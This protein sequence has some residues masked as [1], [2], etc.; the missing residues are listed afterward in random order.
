MRPAL[1][2]I[3]L[4]HDYLRRADLCPPPALLL[5]QAAR[6]LH[7]FR[8]CGLPVVHAHT[9]VRRDGS[10]RMPHWKRADHS[11]CVEGSE[12]TAAPA[13]VAPQPGE[14]VVYKQFFTAFKD[15]E[16]T[17]L[18]RRNGVDTLVVAGVH[19][20]ACVRTSVVDAY[21]AGFGVWLAG[22]AVASY[23]PLHAALTRSYLDGRACRVLDTQQILQRLPRPPSQHDHA[24]REP[25]ALPWG[26]IAGQWIPATDQPTVVRRNPSQWSEPIASVPLAQPSDVGQAIAA[27]AQ[28]QTRWAARPVAHRA[29]RLEAWAA[30]LRCKQDR[31]VELMGKELGKPRREAVGEF[32]YAIR[33]LT[34]TRQRAHESPESQLP[35]GTVVRHRPLGAV[36]LI[37][38][39]NN[40]IA[41]PV[42][43]IA[44]ALLWGNAVVW[45]PAV[46]APRLA[47]L[48]MESLAD[49]DLAENVSMIF[50]AAATART[51]L[52][53]ERIAAISFTGSHAAGREVAATCAVTHKQLQAELGGNNGAVI[54]G[55][56]SVAKAA[57]D[58]AAA[59]FSFGG[60]RCTAT[61][62]VIVDRR[63]YKVFLNELIKATVALAVG[64]V[65][66]AATRLGPL[67]SRS[68]QERIGHV[69]AAAKRGGA[70]VL[71]GGRIPPG[72]E[73]G[74]WY[75]PTILT[76]VEAESPVAQEE[77]FGPVVIISDY[78]DFGEAMHRLNDVPQGLVATLY[79]NDF[80]LQ[81]H[82]CDTAQAGILRLNDAAGPIDADAPFSGWKVS[83]IGPAEHGEGDYA[84]YT[85]PQ[86]VYGKTR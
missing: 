62:R 61:R 86:A 50:G 3:D 37:T 29:E 56:C 11:A 64:P 54:T 38:P 36:G 63:I 22:D 5:T 6:L 78:T 55:D 23:S 49:A 27:A 10:D 15:G 66:D 8:A 19:T 13:E 16:L 72:F 80:T 59:G 42:G 51:V 73:H 83:G 14:S 18:L 39:W 82:F 81:Q 43:K 30:S 53:D 68:Q 35:G 67:V 60:Q 84:F 76:G 69:V 77:S 1:L 52:R 24:E 40:P 75:E 4:Q 65:T 44:P 2:L 7:A 21:Q 31:I 47:M 71:C 85:R 45:K 46:E 17:G 12:G 20:H 25:A 58:I 32:D 34:S 79:S 70:T 48:L 26:M 28:Q 41:I 33:L 9:R 74:C 57:E